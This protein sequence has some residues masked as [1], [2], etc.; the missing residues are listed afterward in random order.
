MCDQEPA[1]SSGRQRRSDAMFLAIPICA[2]LLCVV[3]VGSLGAPI[4]FA[5]ASVGALIACDRPRSRERS[6]LIACTAL[7][8]IGSGFLTAL[9]VL[10][11]LR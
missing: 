10:D 2:A 3:P 4:G 7:A 9:A 11:L 5:L 8:L 1:E 6:K